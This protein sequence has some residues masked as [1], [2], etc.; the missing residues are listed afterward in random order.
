MIQADGFPADYASCHNNLRTSPL[1]VASPLFAHGSAGSIKGVAC[2]KNPFRLVAFV[3]NHVSSLSSLKVLPEVIR[4]PHHD[5]GRLLRAEVPFEFFSGVGSGAEVV[6]LVADTADVEDR[7][8]T[9]RTSQLEGSF[10]SRG[11]ELGP[12][13]F[14][15]LE[16]ATAE[17]VERG[18]NVRLVRDGVFVWFCAHSEALQLTA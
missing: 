16:H 2:E 5:L 15:T 7:A 18:L 6:G 4:F 13:E 12:V 8:R 14:L 10:R 3:E 9:I 11:I 1:F 17:L